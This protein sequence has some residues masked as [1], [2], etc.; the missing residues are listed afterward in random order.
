M[1]IFH[2][3]VGDINRDFLL[4]SPTDPMTDLGDYLTGVKELHFFFCKTCAV[5]CFLF[6]GE[7]E[8]VDVDL[9]ELGVPGYGNPGSKTTVWRA[10]YQNGHPVH[11]PY[12]SVNTHTID[13]D[14]NLF[15]MRDLTEKK[16][17]R[18]LDNLSDVG[19]TLPVRW[20]RPQFGGCY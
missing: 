13:A 11:G 16:Q 4:L 8:V 15:D 14:Q 12:L 5:R 7:S 10:T 2:I 19:K 1:G 20:D 17:V 6:D 18:Y 9:A 3:E